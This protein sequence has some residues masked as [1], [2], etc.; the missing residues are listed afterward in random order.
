MQNNYL[1]PDDHER[2]RDRLDYEAA[3]YRSKLWGRM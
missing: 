3:A 2:Y 1:S